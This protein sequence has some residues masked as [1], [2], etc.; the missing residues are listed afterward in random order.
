[1]VGEVVQVLGLGPHRLSASQRP[2]WFFERVEYGGIICDLG[3]HQAE[4]FLSFTGSDS[5]MV[6]F[7]RATNLHHQAY[8]ELEDF[9]EFSLTAPS[10]ASGYFRVDW[11]TREVSNLGGR[12]A[13]HS[14]DQG[15][16]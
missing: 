5:A 3:S 16:H 14:G 10:G 2:S 13:V 11:F 6:E 4:Q 15:Q 7:A 8:P 12:S 1:M 9:G